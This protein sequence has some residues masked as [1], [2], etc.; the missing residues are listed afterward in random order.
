MKTP[1]PM[2]GLF[3]VCD[4]EGILIH[5]TC[6][7]DEAGAIEFWLDTEKSM[8][9]IGNLGRASRGEPQRCASS[10]EQYEAEGYTVVNV[11]LIPDA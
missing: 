7:P 9:M 4:P 2:S 8:N 6:S 10:W 5:T 11:S 1:R 3:C